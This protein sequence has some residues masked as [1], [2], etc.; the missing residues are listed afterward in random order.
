M[1]TAAKTSTAKKSTAKAATANAPA[2]SAKAPAKSA[3]RAPAKAAKE[4]A[5]KK[6]PSVSALRPKD[7]IA[8]LTA[9][10]REAEAL[11]KQFEAADDV[12]RVAIARKVCQALI[13]H[14]TIEEEIFYPAVKPV[15]EEDMV[16]EAVV[17]HA[18]CKDLIAQILEMDG[19]EEMYGPK[20]TVLSEF[21][22]HHVEEEEEDMFKQAKAS[23]VDMKTLAARMAARK[24]ELMAAI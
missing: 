2:K 4:P 5:A 12:E 21:I 13:V 8:L 20:V 1:A 7:A 16:N 11:F 23:H 10:H 14:T 22:E 19:T 15:T 18:S 3:A 17:E 24:E 6:P 9:D